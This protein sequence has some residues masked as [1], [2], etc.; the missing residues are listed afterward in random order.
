MNL[1]VLVND[2]EYCNLTEVFDDD[3]FYALACGT[4]KIPHPSVETVS[5]QSKRHGDFRC[6]RNVLSSPGYS[7]FAC[8]WYR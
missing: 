1:T 7:M 2:E 8:E 6:E 5:I 3:D 4:L